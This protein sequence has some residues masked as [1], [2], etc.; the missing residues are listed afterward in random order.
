[1][2]VDE[3]GGAVAVEGIVPLRA[4]RILHMAQHPCAGEVDAVA[5]LL[6]RV[7]TGAEGQQQEA[8]CGDGLIHGGPRADG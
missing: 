2:V 6:L 8:E 1:M 7:G 5:G 3:T 4:Q